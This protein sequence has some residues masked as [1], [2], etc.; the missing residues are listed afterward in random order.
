MLLLA[1]HT[2]RNRGATVLEST[3]TDSAA[4]A[5]QRSVSGDLYETKTEEQNY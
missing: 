5:G 2:E 3:V 4:A 1:R